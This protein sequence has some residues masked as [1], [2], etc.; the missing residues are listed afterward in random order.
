[1]EETIKNEREADMAVANEQE[2]GGEAAV[3]SLLLAVETI[4]SFCIS[5]PPHSSKSVTDTFLSKVRRRYPWGWY[6]DRLC[7]DYP[8][9]LRHAHLRDVELSTIA[10]EQL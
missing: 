2:E 1:M 8:K 10:E 3:L 9:L 4:S 5:R 7:G 6:F